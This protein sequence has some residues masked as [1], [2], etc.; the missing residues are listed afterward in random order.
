[1]ASL[2]NDMFFL[3]YK[4][5]LSRY[6]IVTKCFFTCIVSSKQRLCVYLIL[7]DQ[8]QN[9]PIYAHWHRSTT[10]KKLIRSFFVIFKTLNPATRQLV[11]VQP[12]TLK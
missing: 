12:Q 9:R 11:Y 1:M 2:K 5:Q 4:I 10:T 7:H 6:L 3:I 8:M